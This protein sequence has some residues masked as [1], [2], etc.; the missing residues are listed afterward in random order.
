VADYFSERAVP[1]LDIV[2]VASLTEMDLAA[3]ARRE[4][5]LFALV[6]LVKW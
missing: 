5:L 2:E 6:L 4:R 3:G 1:R